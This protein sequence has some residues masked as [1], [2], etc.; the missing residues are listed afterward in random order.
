MCFRYFF[1][2]L[3]ILS[4]NLFISFSVAA[5]AGTPMATRATVE[6]T[7]SA[8]VTKDLEAAYTPHESLAGRTCLDGRPVDG[9]QGD[10]VEYWANLECSYCSILEP[11]QAQRLNQSICIVVRHAP[12]SGYGESL[13]KALNYEALSKFSRN[14]A[15]MFWDSVMPKTTLGIPAPYE[16]ALLKAV[17]DAAIPP[18]DFLNVLGTEALEIVSKDV[19]AGQGYISSTPTYVLAGIRFS[20]CDFKAAELPLA[21]ELAKKAQ[22][23]DESA[24]TKAIA[25]IVNGHM[26]ETM[27]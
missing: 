26:N 21:L 4:L 7:V 1:P 20:A 10:I 2:C 24:I 14:T 18:E 12:S 15:N 22:T 5:H 19:M 6:A 13:K 23:G 9:F 27:L 17:E 25:I 16:A 3:G 11:V 8:D